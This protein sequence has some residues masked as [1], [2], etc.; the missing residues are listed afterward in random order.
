MYFVVPLYLYTSWKMY[1]ES[2]TGIGIL[3]GI[4]RFYRYLDFI[5][6][7]NL[8]QNINTGL[9]LECIDWVPACPRRRWITSKR[10]SGLVLWSFRVLRSLGAPHSSTNDPTPPGHTFW[11][12]RGKGGGE[13][14]G[15]T[16]LFC[17]KIHLKTLTYFT[18]TFL[19]K[20]TD[21]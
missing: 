19:M 12:V 15:C 6:I 8:E 7:F 20:M 5:L 18:L 9:F 16:Q 2:K 17:T 21:Y 13:V 10:A 14:G 3:I 11:G 4:C 1:N